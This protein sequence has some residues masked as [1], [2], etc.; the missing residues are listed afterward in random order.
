MSGHWEEEEKETIY[1]GKDRRV[2]EP[3]EAKGGH[4]VLLEIELHVVVNFQI[5]V[6]ETNLNQLWKSRKFS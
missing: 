4:W 5:W 3:V 1:V 2:Q 6:L